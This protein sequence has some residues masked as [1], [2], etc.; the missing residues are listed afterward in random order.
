M[1]YQEIVAKVKETYEKVDASSIQEH[2]AFQINVT[3]EGEGAFYMEIADGKLRVEPY[4]YYDRDALI[5]T[6]AENLFKIAEAQLDPVQAYTDGIIGVEGNL[7]KAAIL[8]ELSAKAAAKVA[9]PAKAEAPVKAEEPAKT[10]EPVKAEAP[11]KTEEPVKA[12]TPAKVEE[13][14][15]AEAPAKTEEPVK[16]ETPAKAEEPEKAEEAAPKKAVSSKK[17]VRGNR[18]K[19]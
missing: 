9:T 3:G 13:S 11:A 8:K 16:A 14:V 6:S 17:K 7:G 10:E 1:T 18:K 12:E 2:I 5:I 19:R 15:K 4:D